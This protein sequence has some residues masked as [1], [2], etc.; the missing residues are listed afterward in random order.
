MNKFTGKFL[1]FLS[2]DES[3]RQVIFSSHPL[4]MD[5][6]SARQ[7]YLSVPVGQYWK[8]SIGRLM[9]TWIVPNLFLHLGFETTVSPKKYWF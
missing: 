4:A 5:Y 9:F 2:L 1:V 3:F 8:V 7:M 6:V